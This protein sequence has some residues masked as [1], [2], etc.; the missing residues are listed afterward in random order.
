MS[1]ADMLSMSTA[2]AW[3]TAE[4][5]ED[6]VREIRQDELTLLDS[7]QAGLGKEGSEHREGALEADAELLRLLLLQTGKLVGL[8]LLQLL[9][10][11]LAHPALP[12]FPREEVAVLDAEELPHGRRLLR[13]PVLLPVERDDHLQESRVHL[14]GEAAQVLETG[15]EEAL[16]LQHLPRRARTGGDLQIHVPGNVEERGRASPVPPRR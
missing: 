13:R 15:A 1:W 16:G 11:Q 8:S 14:M 10:P 7:I 12:S 9:L 3:K 6:P 2:R 4:W 5:P